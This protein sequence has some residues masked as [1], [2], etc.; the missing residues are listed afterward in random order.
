MGP[1]KLR[2]FGGKR[3]KRRVTVAVYPNGTRV[4]IVRERGLGWRWKAGCWSEPKAAA[5]ENAK[6]EGAK[7]KI[8]EST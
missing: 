5:V 8:E 1:L 3:R 4:R 6:R 2:L 7:I